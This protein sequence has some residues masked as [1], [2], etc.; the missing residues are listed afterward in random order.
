MKLYIFGDVTCRGQVKKYSF[1]TTMNVVMEARNESLKD[2][3]GELELVDAYLT[4]LNLGFDL[5][6]FIYEMTL[7]RDFDAMIDA[8]NE[9]K[10]VTVMGEESLYGVST[11]SLVDSTTSLVEAKVHYAENDE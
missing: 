6:S 11:T 1:E 10:P 7:E 9:G 8:L 3:D 5:E 2:P 4:P